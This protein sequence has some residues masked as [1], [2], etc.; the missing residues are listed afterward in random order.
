[1]SIESGTDWSRLPAATAGLKEALRKTRPPGGVAVKRSEGVTDPDEYNRRRLF[2]RAALDLVTRYPSALRIVRHEDH[3]MLMR[4]PDARGSM[5][6][7]E[8]EYQERAGAIVT[9]ARLE[10]AEALFDFQGDR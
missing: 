5:S 7:D 10:E 3:D 6:P 2:E 4:L 1:M 9:P 8:W